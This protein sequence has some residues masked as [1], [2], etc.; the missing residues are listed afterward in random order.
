MATKCKESEPQN[1]WEFLK[2]PEEARQKCEAYRK[3]LGAECWLVMKDVTTGCFSYEKYNG[4]MNCPW[5]KK[6]NP[7]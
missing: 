4:C 5:Y 3:F 1:C 6:L 2:C 7:T